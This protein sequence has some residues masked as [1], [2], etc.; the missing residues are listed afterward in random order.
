VREVM[1][2]HRHDIVLAIVIAIAALP[3]VAFHFFPSTDG[4]EHLDVTAI[5]GARRTPMGS[6]FREVFHVRTGI[7]P[8][9]TI[10][11]ILGPLSRM[12]S[13]ETAEKILLVGYLVGGGLAFR[14]AAGALHPRGRELACLAV[15]LLLN[16]PLYMGFYNF[17][18]G[19]VA[20]LVI[21]GIW[22]STRGAFSRTLA[23]GWALAFVTAFFTHATALV[24]AVVFIVPAHVVE[25][26]SRMRAGER[27]LMSRIVLPLA[28]T[29]PAAVLALHFGSR[30]K[31]AWDLGWRSPLD[32]LKNF[33]VLDALIALDSRERIVALAFALT[34]GA[35][36]V[37]LVWQSLRR[38]EL[39]PSRSVLV[40][41]GSSI[42]AAIF[43][44]D[45]WTNDAYIMSARFAIIAALL[46]VLVV[47]A[48]VEGARVRW[49]L[50]GASLVVTTSFD[51]VR[52][53]AHARLDR[54]ISDV[55][56]VMAAAAPGEVLVPILDAKHGDDDTSSDG[57]LRTT[58][59]LHASSRFAAVRGV[60][61]LHN[62]LACTSFAPVTFA[63][64]DMNAMIWLQHQIEAWETRSAVFDIEEA[65]ARV[66][67]RFDLILTWGLP[68]PDPENV[69]AVTRRQEMLAERW[70]AI[71][72]A[73]AATLYRRRPPGMPH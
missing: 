49:A 7:S 19:I 63:A 70:D 73:G 38:R 69:D 50:M 1:R 72:H 64:P 55:G 34:L 3:I 56:I 39:A 53:S 46:V 18:L 66:Q 68:R 32:T 42:V 51:A 35:G 37:F 10:Y 13:P 30:F 12:T 43:L 65:E 58:P 24:A 4:P 17:A 59:L 28:A 5:L 60:V 29:L 11:T 15:P 71:A 61:S 54:Q 57:A 40:G 22:L 20:W 8:Y 9:A 26:V 41:L 47:A 14:F 62:H 52:W 6:R 2:R 23:V 45:D 21:V 48:H 36:I 25:L 44:P 27:V 16:Y 31:P 67:R 33:L